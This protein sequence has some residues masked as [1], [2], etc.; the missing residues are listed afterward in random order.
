MAVRA[1][2]SDRARQIDARPSPEQSIGSNGL[3][4]PDEQRRVFTPPPGV[5]KIVLAINVAETSITIDDVTFVADTG[6]AKLLTYDPTSRLASLDDVLISEAAAKQRCGRAGKGSACVRFSS[7]RELEK[8]GARSTR[9]RSQLLMRTG[10]C[11]RE[12]GGDRRGLLEPPDSAA[13]LA[14]IDELTSLGALDEDEHHFTRPPAR[15]AADLAAPGQIDR[16]RSRL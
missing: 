12:G 8:Y 6:R 14:S 1:A 13:V 4:P 5:T 2:K 15:R 10:A 7:D 3:L 16:L 9:C 11:C